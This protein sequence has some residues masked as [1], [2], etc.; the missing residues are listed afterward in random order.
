MKPD[1][2]C[3]LASAYRPGD[4]GLWHRRGHRPR[5]VLVVKSLRTKVRVADLID[6]RTVVL[7]EVM[8]A[9]LTEVRG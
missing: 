6:R 5:R 7:R 4:E 2:T 9:N 1:R 8:P 3:K